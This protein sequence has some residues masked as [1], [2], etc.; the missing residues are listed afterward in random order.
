[1]KSKN[2]QQIRNE[3]SKKLK[4]KS[5]NY[6]Q[7]EL[8]KFKEKSMI[9]MIKKDYSN[10]IKISSF[11]K[12][13]KIKLAQNAI[14]RLDTSVREEIPMNVYNWITNVDNFS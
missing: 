14:D 5:K 11:I 2:T 13:N 3:M 10:L 7:R 8:L 1:M 4:D 6:L 12:Q 9:R